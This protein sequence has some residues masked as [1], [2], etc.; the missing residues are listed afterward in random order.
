MSRKLLI[1][2]AIVAVVLIGGYLGLRIYQTQQ[3]EKA[4]QTYLNSANKPADDLVHYLIAQD[5]KGAK[6][7]F[8][9]NLQNGYSDEFWQKT[10]FPL[11][12]GYKG[13]P[14]L[15]F[16]GEYKQ[17]DPALLPP[18]NPALNQDPRI[19]LYDFTLHGLTYRLQIILIRDQ[20]RWK[21]DSVGGG[22]LAK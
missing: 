5:V 19:Y 9:K 21:I 22:Y 1:G 18:Y 16:N 11:F 15:H 17:S 7:L 8:T 6:T 12:K 14:I 3:A 4:Q 10:F 20:G 2:L 13:W